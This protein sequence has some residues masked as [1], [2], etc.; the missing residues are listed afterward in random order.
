[1]VIAA[2]TAASLSAQIELPRFSRP[3]PASRRSSEKPLWVSLAGR[4]VLGNRAHLVVQVADRRSVPPGLRLLEPLGNGSY[5]AALD[6][7]SPLGVE[8][9]A[10]RGKATIIEPEEKLDSSLQEGRM[11]AW[12]GGEEGLELMLS[13]HADVDVV[14]ARRE[15]A[16]LGVAILE[17]APYF[18]RFEVRATAAQVKQ[19]S[20]ADWVQFLEPS[21]PPPRTKNNAI[22]AKLIGGDLL[23]ADPYS[24]TGRD[25]NIG[26]FDGGGIAQHI[27]FADRLT[28]VE[29]SVVSAHST[30]V[31][32]TLVAA[33]RDPKLKG[34]AP[35]AKLFSWTFR[36]V[37][38][39]MERGVSDFG[40]AVAN[41]SWGEA[42]SSA[43]STCGRY[44]TYGTAER[45][46]DRLVRDKNLTIAFASGNDRDWTDCTILPR[47]GF[48]TIGRPSTAKNIITVGAVDESLAAADFS[49]A[50]PMR[51][52]RIKPDIV[53]MGV[54]VVS[55]FQ[56]NRS[57][58]LSGTS[59]ATPAISG[60]AALLIE[61]YRSRNGE[62]PKA[63]LVKAALLNTARDLGNI[64]PD[65][66]YGYGLAD[67]VAAVKAIDNQTYV[68]NEV[69]PD[70]VKAQ[71]IEVPANT[72]S[73][74]VMLV[75]S[76]ADAVL[77]ADSPIT[78]HLELVLTAPDGVTQKLPLRLSPANP[79]ANAVERA[80]DRDTVKQVVVA[81][82]PAG[83]WTAEVRGVDVRTDSQEFV[84]AWNLAENPVP[85]CSITLSPASQAITEKAEF[86]LLTVTTGNHCS[87][88][89]AEDLPA[90]MKMTGPALRQGTDL[91][92]L[93][94]TANETDGPRTASVRV[95]EKKIKVVQ[96]V[97]CR[98]VDI[99]PGVNVSGDL[100]E[101]DCFFDPLVSA[102]SKLYTFEAKQGQAINIS[103]RSNDL[104]TYLMLLLPNGSLLAADD[105]G[106]DAFGS[107]SRLPARS[108]N[109][110][111]PVAGK[112]TIVATTFDPDEAG[113]FTVRL[114]FVDVPGVPPVD[115][116]R[117]SGCPA[118]V[119]GTISDSS[120]RLGRRGDLFPT[121][122]YQFPGRIGQEVTV[123]VTSTSVD[124]VIYL[125][126]PNGALLATATDNE[127]GGRARLTTVLRDPG[128]FS[129]QVSPFSPFS[130]G[131]FALRIEG[132]TRP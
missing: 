30:H 19:L 13:Y 41:N 37:P 46:Y 80:G 56:T 77:T 22:S 40:I 121:E 1:M 127:G 97:R 57:Q 35:A 25:I 26:I 43:T 66:V 108:G 68:I 45:D 95:G 67:T 112:Y 53:A 94:V 29:S 119:T 106:Y 72:P 27:E 39:K 86:A 118:S 93:S 87:R 55:T 109:L 18:G 62:A 110:T 126:N 76:D 85:P 75:Y 5:V 70:T 2:L 38:V 8:M 65:Y 14:E 100:S 36:N 58:P 7:T 88:W 74:R 89:T 17:D 28:Q 44:G 105:D 128:L 33:G 83:R 81:N 15:L 132:C 32:G 117:L 122:I 12:A 98:P 60:A 123:E 4:R 51:D 23:Q 92:K 11:P 91:A 42:Y 3:Q 84:L 131:S 34:L 129:V 49:S 99:T 125:L 78:N 69:A 130:R 114:E 20:Q 104:D 120:T 16:Q 61:R 47:A 113:S 52:N 101:K 6:L 50:G 54:N 111:L 24:L 73:L 107:D 82:P 90:W 64:G 103:L 96:S 63:A 10:G 9:L 124:T 31:A 116:V 102:Y 59:M 115:P 71:P 21:P 48:Y 79:T